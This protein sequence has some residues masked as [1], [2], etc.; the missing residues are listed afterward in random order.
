MV[1]IEG[2]ETHEDAERRRQQL[3]LEIQTIQAQLGDRQRVDESGRRMSSADYWA[4]KRKAAH[5]LNK[6]LEDLRAIKAWIRE[7]RDDATVTHLIAQL[8]S[9]ID[10]A[11]ILGFEPSEEESSALKRAA[12]LISPIS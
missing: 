9:I 11:V 4:W 6:K 2:I 7:R 10:R 8:A 1:E 5:A 3:T 12:A